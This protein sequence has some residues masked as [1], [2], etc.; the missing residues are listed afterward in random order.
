LGK[1]LQAWRRQP[2]RPGEEYEEWVAERKRALSRT[3]GGE[4]RSEAEGLVRFHTLKDPLEVAARRL[5]NDEAVRPQLGGPTYNA[6]R[7]QA[8]FSFLMAKL[9]TGTRHGY[10][11]AWKQWSWF[12]RA[13]GR[14]PFLLGETRTERKGDEELLLDFMVHL[15]RYFHRTE[16]T[17]KAKLFGIRYHHLVEGLAD[18][19][20]EKGRVWLALGGIKRLGGPE[21]RQLPVTIEMIEWLRGHLAG[22]DPDSAVCWAAITT[23]FF[24]LL[25]A[26]EYVAVD[27]SPWQV[28]RALCGA[29]V[30]ARFEGKPV[31][32]FKNAD[33]VFIHIR[34]LETDQYA[35]GQLVDHVA[36]LTRMQHHFP[37]RWRGERELPLFRLRNGRPLRRSRVQELL[38]LAGAAVG[39]PPNKL[40]SHSLRIGGATALYRH[41]QD[42]ET[43]KRFGRWASNA[44]HAYL[45]A[46]S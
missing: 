45:A 8:K 30:Q 27:G 41:C 39:I 7:E 24:F 18:P 15:V 9:A 33:E 37:E 38:G 1:W 23:A 20:L 13:R 34:G 6:D 40:G 2:D 17:V 44:V 26:G 42:V 32:W 14:D 29:D 35:T 31:E 3:G 46:E 28:E 11:G 19:L 4:R 5:V 43:V 10:D 22:E 12:C 16:G 36:A 21:E 25:R